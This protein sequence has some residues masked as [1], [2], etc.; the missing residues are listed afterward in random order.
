MPGI[1][2]YIELLECI[3]T[4]KASNDMGR[5]HNIYIGQLTT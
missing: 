5:V 4:G 3:G 1:I 2:K